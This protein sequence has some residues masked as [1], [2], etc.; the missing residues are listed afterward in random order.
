[1]AEVKAEPAEAPTS[2]TAT[3][4]KVYEVADRKPVTV[5][6]VVVFDPV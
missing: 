2:F 6:G 1:M 5:I 4:L 3:T